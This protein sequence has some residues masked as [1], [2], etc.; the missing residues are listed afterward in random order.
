[1]FRAGEFALTD[2]DIMGVSFCP[3]L[4]PYLPLYDSSFTNSIINPINLLDPFYGTG[5]TLSALQTQLTNLAKKYGKLI[6]VA[7]TIAKSPNHSFY[8]VLIPIWS[9]LTL[10]RD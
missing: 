4:L 5:A 3:C 2:I 10:F 9:R 7:G 8:L 6:I 1:M